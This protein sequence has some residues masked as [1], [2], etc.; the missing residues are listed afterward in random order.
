MSA[1]FEAA[2]LPPAKV[3]AKGCPLSPLDSIAFGLAADP[4]NY[5]GKKDIILREEIV[6]SSNY[7]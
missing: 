5:H 1:A 4:Y 3:R 6:E 2:L 7:T